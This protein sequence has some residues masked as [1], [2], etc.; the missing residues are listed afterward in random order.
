MS[1]AQIGHY[2]Q[3]ACHRCSDV[4]VHIG[5]KH[6]GSG[7]T[8]APDSKLPTP[9][10]LT[11]PCAPAPHPPAPVQPAKLQCQRSASIIGTLCSRGAP[12]RV[13]SSKLAQQ[14]CLLGFTDMCSLETNGWKQPPSRNLPYWIHVQQLLYYGT[15]FVLQA[16]EMLRCQLTCQK[17]NAISQLF[18]KNFYC[19]EHRHAAISVTHCTRSV[20]TVNGK[21]CRVV[22]PE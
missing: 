2:L 19:L 14:L 17:P 7:T 16:H 20:L 21:S 13:S 1:I 15:V 11:L 8:A 3:L 9:G 5:C 18:T 12:G 4:L 22:S 6:T 10:L